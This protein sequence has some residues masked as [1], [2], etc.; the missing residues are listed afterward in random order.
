MKTIAMS[1]VRR[2]L[3]DQRGQ[4]LPLVA[5]GMVGFLT[6]AGLTIDVSRA[7]IV[8]TQVQGAVGAAA[9]AA[10]PDVFDTNTTVATPSAPISQ[11]AACYTSSSSAS[12]YNYRPDMGTV[13][14]TVTTPCINALLVGTTCSASGYIPNAVRVTE[15]A[16]VPTYFMNIFGIHT[17]TVSV[18]ATAAPQG[19]PKVPYNIAVILDATPSMNS[20]D[21]SSA[22]SGQTEEQCAM[23]GIETMLHELNPCATGGSC[24]YSSTNTVVRVSLFSFPN[25]LTSTLAS[26]YNG[27]TTTGEPYT[28][29]QPSLLTSSP[30]AGYTP[31]TYTVGSGRSATTWTATYQILSQSEDATNIDVN[32][33]TSGYYNA[34]D[35]NNLNPSSI[36]VKVLGN[37]VSTGHMSE[38]NTGGYGGGGGGGVTSAAEAIYAAQAALQ[39]EKTLADATLGKPT[40]NVIIFVSDGQSNTPQS[41][42]PAYNSATAVSP[43][44]DGILTMD[45]T[46]GAY[47]STIDPCQQAMVAAHVAHTLGTRVFGVAYGSETDSCSSSGSYDSSVSSSL[48]AINSYLNVPITSGRQ[49]TPCATVEN[50][51]D[52][53]TDFYAESSSVGCSTTGSNAP[54]NNLA[55]IFESIASQLGTGPRLIPNTLN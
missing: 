28:L 2:A 47:P 19:A 54:M 16:Q 21:R 4:V 1:F 13:T 46:T 23:N 55:S 31:L 44:A 6:M 25:V 38:P 7:Y 14:R 29:P 26:D 49:V 52:S 10:V 32:G 11:A 18:T 43:A 53:W 12:C 48:T 3:I 51:A 33:F 30:N 39:A 42:F 8:R 36:L 45:T 15:T 34:A 40:Y 50:I 41:Q 37:G 9:L 35:T 27:G 17:M 20:T 22:C 24:L 5:L